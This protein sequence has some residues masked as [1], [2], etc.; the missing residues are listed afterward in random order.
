MTSNSNLENLYQQAIQHRT[1]HDCSAYPYEEYKKLFDLVASY[2]PSKIL[3]IGTGIGFTAVVM[4]LANPDGYIE[5]IEKDQ[6]HANEAKNFVRAQNLSDRIMIRN[7]VAELLLPELEAG[8]DLI[9]FDGYQIHYEFLPHYE[10]LLKPDGI[11]FLG[12]NQLTSKTSDRFFE[13]L[14]DQQKWQIVEK[15]ADTTIAKK[16]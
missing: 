8:Y 2:K 16:K 13:E 12:N 15:F 10:R 5:T 4:A 14:N 11:L 6:E 7:E 9:F 3:E 1:E